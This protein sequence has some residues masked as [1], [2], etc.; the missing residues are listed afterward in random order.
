MKAWIDCGDAF[1][2]ADVVRW[3]EAV[4]DRPLTRYGRKRKT[5]KA[6]HVGEREIAAEV[7]REPDTKG[8]VTLLVRACRI[9]S[10]RENWPVEQLKVGTEIR[11]QKKTL[12]KGNIARMAWDDEEA[13]SMVVSA[14]LG[15]T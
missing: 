9:V 6:I 1:I 15:N 7:L 13:R 10:A 11:R 5:G 2:K 14:F 4:F 12:L 8:F 3:T